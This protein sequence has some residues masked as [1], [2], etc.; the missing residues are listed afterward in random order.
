MAIIDRP[1]SADEPEVPKEVTGII[2]RPKTESDSDHVTE[3]EALLA[4]ARARDSGSSVFRWLKWLI[5]ILVLG[6]GVV[7]ASQLFQQ[8]SLTTPK[9]DAEN[10]ALDVDRL[11]RI[12]SVVS[13][14]EKKIEHNQNSLQRSESLGDKVLIDTM[15]LALAQNLIDL[16]KHQDS[17]IAALV[18]LQ[19]VYQTDSDSVVAVLKEQLKSNSDSYK[20]GRVSAISDAIE[21]ME[22]VPE[23]KT[24]FKYFGEKIKKQK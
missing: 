13:L 10:I 6:G 7:L 24:P 1:K 5:L 17:Y 16:E 3:E 11:V 21:L 8:V 12:D 23:D 15:R 14:L 19:A 4:K 22:S 18:D 20:Q 2:S 9:V